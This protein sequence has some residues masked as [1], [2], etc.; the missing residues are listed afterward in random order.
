MSDE[1]AVVVTKEDG[2][3][4]RVE[5]LST[6]LPMLDLEERQ[7]V[8]VSDNVVQMTRVTWMRVGWR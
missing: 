3:V 2:S 8:A 5:C 4:E 7:L 6:N 1:I